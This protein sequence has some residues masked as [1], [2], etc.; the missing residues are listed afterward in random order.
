MALQ[1]LFPGKDDGR[2]ESQNLDLQY[3][4]L[5]DMLDYIV[6]QQPMLLNSE[7]NRHHKLLFTSKTYVVMIQFLLKCFESEL[8]MNN[9]LEGSSEFRSSVEAMCSL[10]EHA[11]SFEGSVEL[12]ANASKALVAVASRIPEV[13]TDSLAWFLLSA[14]SI[15]SYILL[16]FI[17]DRITLCPKGILSKAITWSF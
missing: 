13:A 10:L 9:S 6:K 7:E 12:H 8:E 11:M 15:I 14:L 3:P 16:L 17:G 4:K 1:G 2:T 5:G